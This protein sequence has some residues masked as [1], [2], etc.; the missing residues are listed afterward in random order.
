MEYALV[1]LMLST[2]LRVSEVCHADTADLGRERGHRTLTVKR[3]GGRRQR[4]PLPEDAAAALEDYLAG[5]TGPL[6]LVAGVRITR[7][8]VAYRLRKLATAAG[9]DPDLP[10]SPHS[11]RHTATTQALDADESLRRVQ[12]LMGHRDPRTTTRYDRARDN[13][14]R[15]PVHA[16][17][18]AYRR[19]RK[20][21][22]ATPLPDTSA[23]FG[24]T[25]TMD[26][27]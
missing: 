21:R 9:I 23:T 1:A 12:V 5:R 19:A 24:D 3:K 2:G 26:L 11:L 27:P 25:G 13:V 16:L 6:F 20:R 7:H 17:G 10:I 14:D 8:Q 22:A 15:S 18:A 4:I